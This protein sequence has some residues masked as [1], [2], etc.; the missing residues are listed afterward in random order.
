MKLID[1]FKFHNAK[2]KGFEEY[3]AGDIAFVTNGFRNSGVVGYVTPKKGDRV[4]HFEGISISA[5][6]EATVQKPPF[7]PRGNGG[8]GL[9]VLEPREPMAFEELLKIASCINSVHSWRF[10]Y[11]RMVN[12]ERVKDLEINLKFKPTF[13]K[14][15]QEIIPH[16]KSSSKLEFKNIKFKLF[17]I[18]N[19]FTLERGHFHALD[20]L[21][22]GNYATI[23]R[24]AEDNGVV[25][26]F[27]KPKN[28]KIFPGGTI[29]VATTSG[30]A[31]VQL[32]EFIATDNIVI[33][34]P[35][36]NFNVEDL[37]F[38]ACMINRERWRIS[39]GRQ[40]YKTIFSKTNIFMP[41]NDNNNLDYEYMRTVVSNSYKFSAIKSFLKTS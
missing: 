32:N 38:I 40:C 13:N 8:S 24:I 25:G 2:S 5:F 14:T 29:T 3:S 31:F 35:K 1:I 9:L 21:K 19:F 20:R 16:H 10:S 17:N 28:A 18:T 23:S 26:F 36:I 12:V 15:V 41:V 39:Y 7:L 33:L 30:D 34:I 6:C 37:F 4:F 22:E 11:G 27:S